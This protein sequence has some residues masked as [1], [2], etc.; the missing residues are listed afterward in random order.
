MNTSKNIVEGIGHASKRNSAAHSTQAAQNGASGLSLSDGRWEDCLSHLEKLEPR[1]LLSTVVGPLDNGTVGH[2]F[3]SL[4]ESVNAAYPL[5]PVLL[6]ADGFFSA[7]E[8]IELTSSSLSA[9][10]V[11]TSDWGQYDWVYRRLITVDS[12]QVSGS[13]ADFPLLVELTDA[14]IA[15]HA[16]SDGGDLLFTSDDGTTVLPFEIESYDSAT[17]HL[18]AWVKLPNISDAAD[19]DVYLYYGNP[20]AD[21]LGDAAGV[22]D[23][24]YLTVQH[25]EETSGGL[26]SDSTGNANDGTP[27]NGVDL[28]APAVIGNGDA[29]D[30]INDRIALDQLFTNQTQFS[31]EAWVYTDAKQGY[32]ISQRNSSSQGSFIQYYPGSQTFQFYVDGVR[33]FASAAPNQWHYVV[34]TFDGVNASLYVNDNAV[35]QAAASAVTW[36]NLQ[37]LLGDRTTG[38]RAFQGM[39][40]EVRISSVARSSDFIRTSYANQADAAA[41][42]TV[43]D[44]EMG[45]AGENQYPVI[46]NLSVADGATDVPATTS[47]LTFMLTDY[48]SDLM[49]YTVTTAPDIGSASGVSFAGGLV[50][51]PVAGLQDGQEY[52]W[53]IEASDGSNV[54]HRQFTFT[55]PDIIDNM[56]A[57]SDLEASVDSQDLRDNIFG[58]RDWYESRNDDP[59]LLTLDQ[60]NIGGNATKKIKLTGNSLDNAYVSQEF[61]SPRNGRFTVQW[62][63]YVDE[64][65]NLSSNPDRGGWMFLGQ[66]G[67][68]GPNSSTS[69]HFVHMAFAKNGGG[70][71]GNMDLVARDDNDGW[72]SYTTVSSGLSLD[73]WYTIKVDIDVAAWTYDVYIDDAFQATITARNTLSRVS[74][75]SF[76]TWND[77]AATV[78]FDNIYDQII[79][80]NSQ[81]PIISD[82]SIPNNATNVPYDLT[83]LTIQ[84]ADNQGDLMSYSVTTSP[85]IGSVSGV[86]FAGGLVTVPI[87]GLQPGALYTWTIEASDGENDSYRQLTF[88]TA[89][90]NDL[91]VDSDLEDSLDSQELRD[92]TPG[93]RDW[94]ESRNDDPSLATLD[95]T[96]IGGNATKKIKFTGS[97]LGNAYV[98]QEFGSPRTDNF[99]VQWD[100][101]VAEIIDLTADPDRGAWMFIGNDAS[102]GPNSSFSAQFVSLAF[103][104]DGGGT[105][106]AMDLVAR[107]DD[108]SW[109]SFTTV[110]SG[111]FLDTWYTIKVDVDVTAGTYDVYVDDL[112][113]GTLTAQNPLS[114]VNYIS[115]ATWNDGAATAYFDNI[116]DEIT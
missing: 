84:L 20:T 38:G 55:T 59:T 77:G 111:L 105:T 72:T 107:D 101:Y 74:H 52:I 116:Y 54:S 82:P 104:K 68:T 60:E 58:V 88:S 86:S 96:D 106:G 40:D 6:E 48:Q 27:I 65:V 44:E 34:A 99:T 31:V 80:E 9:T 14:T 66:L 98:S 90:A 76:A 62:D 85:D 13:L 26:L 115:F 114:E 103:A 75:I 28:D 19:T 87:S 22:W 79:D 64:I 1:L 50:T 81:Q 69:A 56:L 102:N 73:N 67:S 95:Q 24:D 109:T 113:Q 45:G 41:F 18:L 46:S 10:T 39:L 29:F 100:V 61:S 91:L 25:L 97:S 92:D 63:V 43:G 17:G 30:G 4:Q 53:T 49:S 78:Y 93:L 42:L 36:P 16:Q 23:A 51:V 110:S 3:D 35:Q 7:T 32:V 37:T 89:H 12:S 2:P 21:G 5:D 11:P 15:L 33:V 47:E 8:G 70:T 57:D 71:N 108:D 83:E 94:Y 112:L